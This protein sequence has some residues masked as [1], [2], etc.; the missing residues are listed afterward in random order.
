MRATTPTRTLLH[1]ALQVDALASGATGALLALAAGALAGPLQLPEPLMRGAGVA[2][3]PF[4]AAVGWA[5][6]CA[7]VPRGAALAIVAVNLLWVAASV[8][9]VVAASP[10]PTPLGVAFV[11]AQALAVLAFAAAQWVGLRRVATVAPAT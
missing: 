2:L 5:G 9:V 1:T 7:V 8:A 4:A 11:L 3:V 10:S 6:T